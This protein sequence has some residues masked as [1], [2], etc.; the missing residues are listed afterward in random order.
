[1]STQVTTPALQNQHASTRHSRIASSCS[2][3][4][5]KA[6][7]GVAEAAEARV[8]QVQQQGCQAGGGACDVAA[9]PVKVRLA[10]HE[11]LHKC[12]EALASALVLSEWVMPPHSNI[13]S[14]LLLGGI[15]IMHVLWS[16]KPPSRVSCNGSPAS[17][18]V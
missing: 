2:N 11:C 14:M 17:R 3:L 16:L 5:G 13:S 12:Q 7:A 6:A 9:S 15:F 4:G 1:M 8:K 18:V 10:R